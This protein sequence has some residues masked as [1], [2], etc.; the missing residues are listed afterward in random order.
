MNAN[1]SDNNIHETLY[2]VSFMNLKAITAAIICR[3]IDI[4]SAMS[5][6]IREDNFLQK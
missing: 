3:T 6:T 1:E 2:L 5:L 4:I